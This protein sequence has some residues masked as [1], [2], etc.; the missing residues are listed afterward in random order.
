MEYSKE[1]LYKEKEM[2]YEELC[3]YLIKKYGAVQGNY[4]LTESMKS[5]NQKITRGNE[6]LFVHHTY[7]RKYIM[8]SNPA[9]ASRHRFEYQFGENLVYCNYIEHFLLHLKIIQD[10]SI[11]SEMFMMFEWE[12]EKKNK[13][14]YDKAI[15][16]L[17]VKSYKKNK[18]GIEEFAGYRPRLDKYGDDFFIAELAGYGGIL[19][20]MAPEIADYYNGYEYKH[21]WRYEAFKVVDLVKD[22]YIKLLEEFVKTH[23]SI[24]DYNGLNI[25]EKDYFNSLL[26]GVMIK[27]GKFYKEYHK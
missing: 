26:D 4:F 18:K 27:K 13:D 22:E 21:A 12:L 16:N 24:K 5:K 14:I 20:F 9:F 3:D 19:N 15:A 7:E 25:S 6:G 2:N 1:E 11:P 17:F 8:L 23:L 10:Y